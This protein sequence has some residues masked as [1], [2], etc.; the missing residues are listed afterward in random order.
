MN[1]ETLK[2]NIALREEITTSWDFMNEDDWSENMD[3]FPGDYD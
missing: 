2:T 1:T 3:Y